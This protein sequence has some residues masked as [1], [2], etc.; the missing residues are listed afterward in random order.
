MKKLIESTVFS[1]N[2][3]GRVEGWILDVY[4]KHGNMVIWL[5]TRNDQTARLVDPWQQCFY[6][7]GEYGDLRVSE[8]N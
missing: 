6:V 4:P 7:A 3:I 1:K 5:K 2:P 8:P